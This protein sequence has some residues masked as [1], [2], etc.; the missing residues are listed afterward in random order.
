MEFA[1]IFNEE[2][3]KKKKRHRAGTLNKTFFDLNLAPFQRL[4]VKPARVA[5]DAT[6]LSGSQEEWRRLRAAQEDAVPTET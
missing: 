5:A 2:M 6:R 4:K 1:K 3:K